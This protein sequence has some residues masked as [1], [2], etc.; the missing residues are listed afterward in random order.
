V[1]SVRLYGDAA[2]AVGS[3][4]QTGT[5]RGRDNSARLRVTQ[6]LIRKGGDWV[7]ASLH[8]SPITPAPAWVLDA[9]QAGPEPPAPGG[10]GGA[11]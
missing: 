11:R 3:Q 10:P 9:L 5:F 2:I 7:I 8:L 4:V 6:V 1:A